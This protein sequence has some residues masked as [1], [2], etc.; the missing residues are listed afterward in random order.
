MKHIFLIASILACSIVLA[1]AITFVVRG[2][3]NSLTISKDSIVNY[4]KDNEQK[5]ADLCN[6]GGINDSY[7]YGFTAGKKDIEQ[8]TE[9]IISKSDGFS[10]DVPISTDNGFTEL[11]VKLPG[12]LGNAIYRIN[13]DYA[14]AVTITKGDTRCGTYDYKGNISDSQ[15]ASDFGDDFYTQ[16][17]DHLAKWRDSNGNII[18]EISSKNIRSKVKIL[19]NGYTFIGVAKYYTMEDGSKMGLLDFETFY[20]NSLIIFLVK[21]VGPKNTEPLDTNPD[22]I[23]QEMLSSMFHPG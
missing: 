19:A 6:K 16:D 13:D 3:P 20:K 23:F 14:L 11:P 7:D 18:K 10:I 21:V 1:V 8:Q 5:L 17:R 22:P 4:Q 2:L 12:G 9:E 15:I